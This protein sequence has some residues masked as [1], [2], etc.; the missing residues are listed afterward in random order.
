MPYFNTSKLAAD[1]AIFLV[2]TGLIYR[3]LQRID[4]DR[5][6]LVAHCHE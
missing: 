3:K 6:L 4:F 2:F 5:A 1:P